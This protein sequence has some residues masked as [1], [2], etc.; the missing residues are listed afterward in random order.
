MSKRS[1][2]NPRTKLYN[3]TTCYKALQHNTNLYNTI[4]NYNLLQSLQHTTKLYS[5]KTYYKNYNILENF[6][7]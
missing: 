4:K 1:S 2:W 6:T 5:F 3:F 7:I